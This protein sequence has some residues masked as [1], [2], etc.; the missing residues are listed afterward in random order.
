MDSL[1]SAFINIPAKLIGQALYA[2]EF[3]DWIILYDIKSVN[4]QVNPVKTPNDIQ[5]ELTLLYIML[6]LK[7]ASISRIL[8]PMLKFFR[9]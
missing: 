9:K 8:L 6:T 5:E 4:F 1:I 2:K 7:S 3:C